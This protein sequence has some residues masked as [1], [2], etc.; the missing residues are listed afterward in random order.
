MDTLTE[1]ER[2]ALRVMEEALT[3]EDHAPWRCCSAFKRRRS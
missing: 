3:A 1:G 2:H